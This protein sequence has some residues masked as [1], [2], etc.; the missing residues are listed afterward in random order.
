M[1]TKGG[2]FTGAR[3]LRL[4]CGSG[5][6]RFLLFP[7]Q[8][9]PQGRPEAAVVYGGSTLVGWGMRKLRSSERRSPLKGHVCRGCGCKGTGAPGEVEAEA[10]G[11]APP[12]RSG[13]GCVGS[14]LSGRMRTPFIVCTVFAVGAC[15]VL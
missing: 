1:V 8:L 4:G 3:R 10:L 15:G 9:G 14:G 5:V 2:R 12:S 13:A 11:E 7:I 6:C